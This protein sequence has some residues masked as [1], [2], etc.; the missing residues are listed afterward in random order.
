LREVINV[1]YFMLASGVLYLSF[2][3]FTEEKMLINWEH[4]L[5]ERLQES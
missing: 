3:F 1:L 5:A 4:V 2:G